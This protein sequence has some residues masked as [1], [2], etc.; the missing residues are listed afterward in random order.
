[1]V[2]ALEI[3]ECTQ[4]EAL[5]ILWRVGGVMKVSKTH[6]YKYFHGYLEFQQ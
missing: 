2:E 1:M 3:E 4:K 5:R 6:L